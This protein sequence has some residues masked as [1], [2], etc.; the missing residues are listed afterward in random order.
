MER[1]TLLS[2]GALWPCVI[3]CHAVMAFLPLKPKATMWTATCLQQRAIFKVAGFC[4]QGPWCIVRT[5]LIDAWIVAT[6]HK[7]ILLSGSDEGNCVTAHRACEGWHFRRD[8]G[9]IFPHV[10]AVVYFFCP[11]AHRQGTNTLG[12]LLYCFIWETGNSLL[13]QRKLKKCLLSYN[14][15]V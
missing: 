10:R 13:A 15:M 2:G 3:L 7:N 1:G 9:K 14:F 12:M 6:Q 4:L 11:N 8:V 5:S